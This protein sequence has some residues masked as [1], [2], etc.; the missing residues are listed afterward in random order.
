MA[1]RSALSALLLLCAVF[2]PAGALARDESAPAETVFLVATPK[3]VDPVY[4]HAV[5]VAVPQE[6]DR[7]VGFILNRPTTF[8]LSS[9]FPQHEPSKQVENPV[10]FGGPMSMGTVFALV[11]RDGT[12]ERGSIEAMKDLHIAI[13]ADIIDRIIETTPNE[14]RYFVGIVHWR[15]GELNEELR[16]GLWQIQ[17][18][19]PEVIFRK[20][21]SKLWE[22]LYSSAKIISAQLGPIPLQRPQVLTR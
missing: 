2:G 5:L 7:H 14:A 6:N 9:L 15:P 22:E 1:T 17:T 20:D 3:L 16:R 11:K 4:Y 13:R 10:L 19:R 21:T 18:A 12:P 8:S